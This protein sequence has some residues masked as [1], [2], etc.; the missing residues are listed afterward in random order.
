[1][2]SIDAPRERPVAREYRGMR[3]G[4]E[5]VRGEFDRLTLVLAI[6]EGC[7]ACD[8]VLAAPVDAFGAVATLLVAARPSTSPQWRAT[9]HPLVI[10]ELLLDQL[11]VR[12][13][14][15]YVLISPEGPRVLTEGV[16]M[17]PAQVA[18]E[19]APFLV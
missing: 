14:P 16:L 3:L 10:S 7:L 5:L 15:F 12:W 19:I 8:E 13:P 4:G 6:K 11:D 2:R 18:Q 17:G 1:M 9:S